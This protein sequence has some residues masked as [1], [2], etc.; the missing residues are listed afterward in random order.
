MALAFHEKK[1]P[2]R[3]IGFEEV[4]LKMQGRD[5]IGLIPEYDSLHRAYQ[6]FDHEDLVFDCLHYRDFG[7]QQSQVNPFIS[8]NPIE[9]LFPKG[10]RT[11]R[12]QRTP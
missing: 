11:T 9:P 12:S 6:L 7:R 8:W 10:Q 2:F 4:R 1:M 5:Y 3:W